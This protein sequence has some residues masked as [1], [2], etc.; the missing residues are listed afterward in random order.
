MTTCKLFG[1]YDKI[2]NRLHTVGLS[3]SAGAFVRDIG[4]ML[5]RVNPNFEDEFILYEM[6]DIDEGAIQFD[7]VGKTWNVVS[8]DCYKAPERPAEKIEKGEMNG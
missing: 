8:W 1:V 3:T 2:A 6:A 4:K 7:K 5:V